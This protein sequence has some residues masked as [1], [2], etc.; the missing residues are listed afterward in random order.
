MAED[1][2]GKETR[3]VG[4]FLPTLVVLGVLVAAL[5]GIAQVWTDVRWF[6][7]LGAGQVFWKQFGWWLALGIFGFAVVFICALANFVFAVRG[8]IAL[9]HRTDADEG[10]ALR[11]ISKVKVQIIALGVAAVLGLLFGAPLASQWRTYLL[12]FNRTSFGSTDAQFGNDIGFYVFTF[13]MLQSL[14]TFFLSAVMVAAMA[15]FVGYIYKRSIQG[16]EGSFFTAKVRRHA[17]ILAAIAS[18]LV[19]A[20]FWLERYDL[21]LANNKKFSGASFT[22]INAT[23]PGLTTLAIVSALVSVLFIVAAV[24]NVFKPAL[25]G[26]AAGVVASLVVGWAYP[27]LVQTFK[28]TPN[29]VEMESP[30]I[31]RNI[32]ATRTAYG[33][34]DIETTNYAATSQAAAGQ[35]RA[36]ADTTAQ[37]RLLDPSIVSPTFNQLQQNR[38]YYQF[39]DQ[40]TVDRYNTAEKNRD[41]VIAVRE[42]N[43]DGLDGAQRTWVNDHT[44]YTHGYGVAAAYG[45]TTTDRGAPVFFQKDIPS[46]GEL[47]DYEARVYFGQR[48]PEYSIVGAP[49]G[50]Q[51][52][53]IDYPDDKAENG[54]IFT[55]YTGDGGPKLSNAWEKLMYAIKFRSTDMF[56]SD[57]VTSSSQILYDR[58]PQE[59][60][61]KVAPYLTLDSRAYPAIVDMDGDEST[62][63][64]LVWIVDAYTTSNNYPYSARTSLESAIRD[65]QSSGADVYGKVDEINY[66]RN[67]VKAVVD[68]YTGKVTLYQWDEKDPVLHAW[69]NIFPGMLT[70]VSEMSGDLMAHMRYPEDMFKVQRTL[71][72]KY[73]VRDAAAF[74]S[75]G[76]FWNVPNEPTEKGTT[77]SGAARQ[78]P[79]FYLT[80]QM[81]GQDSAQFSL[82]SG[83]VPGG[84]TKRNVMTGFLAVDSNAGNEPGKIREGYGKLRLLELPRDSTVPGPGQAENN[85]LT[86]PNV[87]RNLNLLDQAGT[88]VTLGNLLTLPV[89][90]GLLY[91][92]PV[93]VSAASGTQYPLVQYVL[94]AFG[95]DN[96]IG[97]APTLDEA[98]NQTFGGDSGASAGD[99]DIDK[100]ATIASG[101]VSAPVDAAGDAGTAA[102]GSG[103]GGAADSSGAGSDGQTGTSAGSSA[104]SSGTGSEGAAAA[105]SVSEA[106][107]KAQ[108]A[109][110]A[111]QDAMK[112]GDWAAYGKAQAELQ[113]ALDAAIAAQN[114]GGK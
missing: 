104:T 50:E 91:V 26:I 13:P 57:R 39:V 1:I 8:K 43:L 30:Y 6:S 88:K 44:V 106:L 100:D 90:G 65:A 68:A 54:Q 74:Y 107:G 20:N 94:T 25:T 47:G 61:S 113:K 81:P 60:V 32:D 31:Q 51:P 62:P 73:H 18:M 63:K 110:K 9:G 59:R 92:Q 78:Q 75:G 53:E 14:V 111:A 52:W 16:G 79:P 49:K 33:L 21:L 96:K 5:Y 71:L 72:T 35:L 69:G 55:T 45:N 89:G 66:V 19:A 15:G 77:S 27:A 105:G 4:V 10:P 11:A 83:F 85:F 80:L 40:L 112:A 42:L 29:A 23:L 28:V 99:A 46:T 76:D 108:A 102:D 22:D 93:Y 56:F 98:L 7:Q 84:T 82:T 37:I 95:D 97:F 41:T 87:S 70:P 3:G 12:W 86:D 24:R 114:A 34:D 36:D 101:D 103:S 2:Q 58:D 67:S 48:S 38:Q 17:A 64:R 109:M